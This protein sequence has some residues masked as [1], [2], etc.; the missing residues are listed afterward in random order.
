MV[1]LNLVQFKLVHFNISFIWFFNL[2]DCSHLDD[3]IAGNAGVD[4]NITKPPFANASG[5]Q[6]FE[7]LPAK[8]AAGRIVGRRKLAPGTSPSLRRKTFQPSLQLNR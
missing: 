3:V 4:R 5:D 1:K 6:K 2:L 7:Q 8:D